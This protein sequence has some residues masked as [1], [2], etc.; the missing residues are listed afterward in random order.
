VLLAGCKN[1]ALEEAR[2]ET[3]EAKAAINKLNYSLQTIQETIATKDAELRAVQQSR[4]E[5]QKQVDQLRRE[6]DA[7]SESA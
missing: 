6:R 7:A 5:L 3:R 4:D 2:Q 1:Q